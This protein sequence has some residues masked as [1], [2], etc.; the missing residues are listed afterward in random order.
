MAEALAATGKEDLLIVRQSSNWCYF[1]LLVSSFLVALDLFWNNLRTSLPGVIS[2]YYLLRSYYCFSSFWFALDLFWNNLRSGLPEV[3]LPD[4]DLFSKASLF[5]TY[6]Y[7]C[8]EDNVMGGLFIKKHTAANSISILESASEYSPHLGPCA[9]CDYS[10][11]VEEFGM[12]QLVLEFM[13]EILQSL[14]KPIT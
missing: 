8:D 7:F 1:L 10:R 4:N 2:Y 5:S 9:W 14:S 12:S 13:L 11:R 3:I 6:C